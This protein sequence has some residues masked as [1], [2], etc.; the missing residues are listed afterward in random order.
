MSKSA[1]QVATLIERCLFRVATMIEQKDIRPS[2]LKACVDIL[3][4]VDKNNREL[5]S[6]VLAALPDMTDE[7]LEAELAKIKDQP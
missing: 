3:I 5:K 1:P 4:S 6:S 7:Q 2:D